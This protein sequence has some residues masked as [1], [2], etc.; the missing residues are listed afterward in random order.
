MQ[1]QKKLIEPT[2]QDKRWNKALQVQREEIA[3][4][5]SEIK[6]KD[7]TIFCKDRELRNLKAWI[8]AEQKKKT[9]KKLSFRERLFWKKKKESTPKKF[10]NRPLRWKANEVLDMMKKWYSD[11]QIAFRFWTSKRNVARFIKR[12]NFR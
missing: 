2:A 12:H 1:Q 7:R 4:L 3:Y 6:R 8:K 11:S 9:V 10:A 5:R